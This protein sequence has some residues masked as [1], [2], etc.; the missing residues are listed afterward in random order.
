MRPVRVAS[1]KVGVGLWA[2][3]E[4]DYRSCHCFFCL[5]WLSPIEDLAVG[6]RNIVH[7]GIRGSNRWFRSPR[8]SLWVAIH[9]SVSPEL[10]KKL[11]VVRNYPK[12]IINGVADAHRYRKARKEGN[13]L[14]TQAASTMGGSCEAAARL[15]REDAST[16]SDTSASYCKILAK[17]HR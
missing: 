14:G 11:V 12:A 1:H 15:T 9:L 16:R 7:L 3:C 6:R 8:R 5:Y 2:E 10:V 17:I 4:L 13:M